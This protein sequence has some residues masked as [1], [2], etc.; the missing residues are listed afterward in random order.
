MKASDVFGG[1]YEVRHLLGVGGMAEVRD[2]WDTR[3]GRPVAIKLLHPGLAAQPDIRLRFEAEARASAGLNHPN[4][5]AVYDSGDHEGTPFI[6]MERLPG[7]TLGDIIAR[8][9]MPYEQVSMVVDSVLAAL[10][11]AHSG[12]VLHRDIKPGNILLTS[13]GTVK[14][15]DFGIAK[16]PEAAHTV[17][18]QIVGT[19]AYLSP[20]RLTGSP[21]SVADD[22]YAV[23]VV[24]YEALAGQRPYPQE[25]FV[26]L[27]HAITGEQQPAPL[28]A[29]RPDAHPLLIGVIER[30][31]AQDPI[32]RFVGADA[33]RGA[34]RGQPVPRTS[35]KGGQSRPPTRVLA[36]PLPPAA[37]LAVPPSAPRRA[38]SRKRRA[39]WFSGLA[40]ALVVAVLAFALDPSTTQ[41]GTPEPVSTSTP[42]APPPTMTTSPTPP[43]TVVEQSTEQELPGGNG[44]GKHGNSKKRGGG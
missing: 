44:N 4:I 16:T 39:L 29:L 43:P 41:P 15:A 13:T 38:P 34:L 17:A 11:A 25:N 30:A 6:V 36:E 28:A 7:E 27:A 26:Q 23:G 18:G 2:G 33:M 5:V 40:A 21:A 22:L 10:D 24:G 9:P 42:V 19:L 32:R 12:G 35:H 8:G 1:R 31:M 3:L 37:T 14:V 20:E